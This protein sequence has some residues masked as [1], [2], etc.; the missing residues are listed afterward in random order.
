MTT[1]PTLTKTIFFLSPNDIVL[2]GLDNERPI[3]PMN[4]ARLKTKVKPEL[5]DSIHTSN[6]VQMPILVYTRKEDGKEETVADD[7]RQR[8]RAAR[9]VNELREKHNSGKQ[10]FD[11]VEKDHKFEM[12]SVP[13][14]AVKASSDLEH[15]L[16]SARANAARLESGPRELAQ[17]SLYL[18]GKGASPKQISGAI[19]KDEQTVGDYLKLGNASSKVIA[20][21]DK[22][23]I[24]TTAAARLATM[25]K[26]EQNAALDELVEKGGGKVTKEAATVAANKKRDEKKKAA[27]K[28]TKRANDG[29]ATKQESE[30]RTVTELRNSAAGLDVAINEATTKEERVP[31]VY[32]RTYLAF[33]LGEGYLDGEGYVKGDEVKETSKE[34]HKSFMRSLSQGEKAIAKAKKEAEKAKAEA[35]K[36]AAEE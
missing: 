34:A 17:F 8:V 35:K 16:I 14:I 24:K 21:M 4:A 36:G 1:S 28:K 9:I 29:K 11:G 5:I 19:G 13:C 26:D 3:D 22:G 23:I 27:G 12:I 6:E 20:A 15:E 18:A 25:T 2:D 7:G 10:V 32:A 30:K 31:L 33:V